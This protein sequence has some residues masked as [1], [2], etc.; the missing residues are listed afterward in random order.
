MTTTEELDLT[1]KKV[2]NDF[3]FSD[4]SAEFAPFR[5]LKVRW[6]RTAEWASFQVSDYL[7]SAP[8]E[9][10]EGIVTTVM[11]RIR[12]E[13][14]SYP[15]ETVEWLTSHEF[16]ELNQETYIQ[17]SRMIAV[18]LDGDDRLRESYERLVDD[19]LIE[20]IDDLRLIIGSSRSR[21]YPCVR[22]RYVSAPSPS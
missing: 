17:R 16:R 1:F 21:T 11:K 18:P 10:I 8:V 20:R 2:G 7:E 22:I 9:V 13:E 19:G 15:E 14:D 12:G 5:D 6:Q 3:G 4:V